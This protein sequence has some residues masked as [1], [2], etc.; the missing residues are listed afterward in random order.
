[1]TG[2]PEVAPMFIGI[3]GGGT[4][5]RAVLL[6]AAG[7]IRARVDGEA[8]IIDASDPARGARAAVG[9][10]RAVAA[11]ASLTLPVAGLCAGLAGAGR[12]AERAAVQAAIESAGVSGRVLVTGDA[13][14]AMADAF[15]E[16]PGVLLIAGTGSI[17]WA[18]SADGAVHRTGG[19]GRL[20]GDEGSGF[21]I[22]VS[23]VRAVLRAWDGRARETAL[24]APV[25]D[26]TGSSAPP[27]IV[28]FAATATKAQVAALAPIVLAAAAA[29]D[30]A[31]RTICQQAEAALVE[32]AVTAAAKARRAA[33]RIAMA[34]GL[35]EPGGPL[36]DS[37]AA[38][39]RRALPGADLL[40]RR[41][42]A[43]L[44]AA[45]MALA[46]ST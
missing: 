26:A 4:R 24:S 28:R 42:D 41:V 36:H 15:G 19:W 16:D 33:P 34:G 2:A 17:A 30:A 35:I 44:G 39:L 10:A 32:L 6:D 18:R 8:G 45:R 23:A 31:A 7:A 43:A 37:I 9:L 40:E 27:D 5:A 1:M 20:I 21:D 11:Q 22:G 12:E 38:A 29:G 25:L 46:R 14:A 3:D 13:E